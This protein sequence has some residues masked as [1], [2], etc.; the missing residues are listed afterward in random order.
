MPPWGA[1]WECAAL[2]TKMFAAVLSHLST[3]KEES[4][5]PGAPSKGCSSC[6]GQGWMCVVSPHGCLIRCHYLCFACGRV[7]RV[8]H[9]TLAVYQWNDV[10]GTK[11]LSWLL[12]SHIFSSS[13]ASAAPSHGHFLLRTDKNLALQHGLLFFQLI[14]TLFAFAPFGIGN[15]GQLAH[16]PLFPLPTPHT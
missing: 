16:Q 4:R 2:E 5:Q 12:H 9:G 11:Q 3:R 6:S 13:Q 10:Q 1:T 8:S 14:R 7:S 15:L